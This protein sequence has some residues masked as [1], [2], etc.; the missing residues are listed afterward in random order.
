MTG[1]VDVPRWTSP[2]WMDQMM[3]LMLKTPGLERL[4]GRSTALLTVTGRNTGRTITTPVS[5]AR[6]DGRVIVTSHRTRQWWRNVVPNPDV[7]I[8]LVGRW[9]QGTA[10]VV[11]DPEQACADFSE[12]LDAQPMVAKLS[13]ITRDEDGRPD[14]AAVRAALEYTVIVEIALQ[15]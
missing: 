2:A 4:V 5:Y 12:F 10:R 9:H 14:Q 8:R 3:T 6:V 11:A 15:A 1:R 13:D 7:A